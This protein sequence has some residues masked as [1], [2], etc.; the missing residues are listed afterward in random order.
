M[1]A[2]V[3]TTHAG[4]TLIGGGEVTSGDLAQALA[5]APV[6]VAADSGA[7][8]ALADGIMPEAVLGDLDSISEAARRAIPPDRLHRIPEQETT[9]FEK[10]LQRLAAPFVVAVGFSGPRVD[11]LLAGLTTLVRLR[12]SPCLLLA[13]ADAVFAAPARLR[14]DLPGGTR[15]SLYPLGPVTGTSRGLRWPIDGLSLDPARR[16]GTSNVTTGQPV[17]LGLDG[18][19][20]VILPREHTAEAVRA[21]RTS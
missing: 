20:L 7:D 3:V 4:I 9:D 5:L 10:C 13:G 6:V 11:H 14:L 17:E 18:P 12:H 2:P 19:C 15:L 16:A 8:R 21:I 1:T